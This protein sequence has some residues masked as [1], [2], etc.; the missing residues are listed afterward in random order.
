V[1]GSKEGAA[2]QWTWTLVGPQSETLARAGRAYPTKKDAQVA[3]AAMKIAAREH[4][5]PEKD[6]S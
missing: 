5:V 1:P 3:I 2:P 4:E 6:C